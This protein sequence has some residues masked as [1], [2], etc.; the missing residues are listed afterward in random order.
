M[1]P[2]EGAAK[3]ISELAQRISLG[4]SVSQLIQTKPP[5]K[6]SMKALGSSRTKRMKTKI[7]KKY[8]FFV[9]DFI[10]QELA[11]KPSYYRGFQSFYFDEWDEYEREWQSWMT[12][13]E[14]LGVLV[15]RG[16]PASN[17]RLE[18]LMRRKELMRQKAEL[19]RARLTDPK[20]KAQ[21]E[22]NKR[23]REEALAEQRRCYEQWLMRA[24]RDED[25]L[26]Y[27]EETQ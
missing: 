7:R 25:S 4:W 12:P 19:N 9:D 15:T 27:Q 10:A 8:G 18:E 21:M 5:K 13:A 20:F 6:L 14:A 17:P 11:A 16:I 2:D 1:T 22:E 23:R 26:F 3:Q 24:D